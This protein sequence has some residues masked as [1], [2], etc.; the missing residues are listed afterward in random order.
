MATWP[1]PQWCA[2]RTWTVKRVSGQPPEPHPAPVHGLRWLL[3]LPPAA[4][5][6][7]CTPLPLLCSPPPRAL[8]L[9]QRRPLHQEASPRTR[10]SDPWAR[11]VLPWQP[12]ESRREGTLASTWGGFG[13]GCRCSWRHPDP[14]SALL[15]SPSGGCSVTKAQRPREGAPG[16]ACGWGC[17]I[18]RAAQ[19]G[20]ALRW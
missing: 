20:W 1:P 6:G 15:G 9:D 14:A 5:C 19:G 2:R 13:F 17:S 18:F 16:L 7:L 10:G 12:V 3:S 8:R 4:A 11:P